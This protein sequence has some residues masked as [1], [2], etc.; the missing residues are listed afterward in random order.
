MSEYKSFFKTVSG[1]EGSLCLYPTRL[2]T[3]GK[4]C[5]HNCGYCYAKSLLEFRGLWDNI[6]PS[7]ADIE[8]VKRKIHKLPPY[9][10]VLRLGGMTDCFQPLEAKDRVTYEAVKEL[11]KVRIGYL[12]VTKSALV[13]R[14]DYMKIYDPS[15]AHIQVTITATDDEKAL[16]YEH[17]S[18]VSDRIAAIERLHA[19]G[20]D[21]AI[22]L[23]P[24]IP[25]F[26]DIDKINKIKCD[27]IVVEFLR[28]NTFIK[29]NFDIDYS[30]YTVK[31]GGYWHLPLEKKLEYLG[32]ITIPEVTVCDDVP[33]HYDYFKKHFNYNPSDCC[34]LRGVV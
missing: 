3:Y 26:I 20:F 32:N 5:Q 18:K 1:N 10:N 11:N 34:N 15:L 33:E 21:V 23:P 6:A 22:R 4:G 14:S 29:R 12:I 24:F 13:A 30:G 2:D 8:K 16:E 17:A 19:A 27:K 9:V 31:S 25:E 7:P 28:C